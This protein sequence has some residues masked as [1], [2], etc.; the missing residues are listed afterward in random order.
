[1]STTPKALELAAALTNYVNKYGTEDGGMFLMIEA[2]NELRRQHGEIEGLRAQVASLVT[3]LAECRDV[4]PMPDPGAALESTW[5]QA[6]GD[7]ESVPGYV[8]AQ[9]EALKKAA[10]HLPWVTGDWTEAKETIT[11]RGVDDNPAKH[12][13]R[14][15]FEAWWNSL[16]T[17]HF[18]DEYQVG[19]G[20]W[21]AAQ[22]ALTRPAVPE[23]WLMDGSMPTSRADIERVVL[24]WANATGAVPVSSSWYGE[25]LGMALEAYDLGAWQAAAPQPEAA[26]KG[27]E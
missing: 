4:F 18:A 19:W 20:T 2:I 3:A 9:V 24:A 7:P 11:F 5:G 15:A 27:G 14:M 13:Q 25:I 21:Q 8:R 23:G 6:M 17:D 12:Q 1:M 26:Q 10:E 16:G 22:Q